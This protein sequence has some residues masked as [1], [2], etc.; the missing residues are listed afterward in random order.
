MRSFS[1]LL[2]TIL[3]S[4]IQF[5]LKSEES[6]ISYYGYTLGEGKE[7]TLEKAK[8]ANLSCRHLRSG[9]PCIG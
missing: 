1:V 3:L 8:Q 5:E 7:E 9:N 6:P 2:I 4:G